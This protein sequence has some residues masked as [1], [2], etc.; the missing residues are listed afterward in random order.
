MKLTTHKANINALPKGMCPESV[1]AWR[2][3]PEN[4]P[5]LSV[6]FLSKLGY[7]FLSERL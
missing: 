5:F 2:A 6:C 4:T 3:N 7:P 1:P